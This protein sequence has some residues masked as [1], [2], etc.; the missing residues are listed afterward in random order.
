VFFL[1]KVNPTSKTFKTNN[2]SNIILQVSTPMATYQCNRCS[3]TFNQKIH[4]INHLKKINLCPPT[5]SDIL[6]NELLKE[7]LGDKY[8]SL[9]ESVSQTNMFTRLA[10][11]PCF[12]VASGPRELQKTDTYPVINN[13]GGI[14]I[15]ILPP[16][17]NDGETQVLSTTN[18]TNVGEAINSILGLIVNNKGIN[19]NVK[20]IK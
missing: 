6:P 11:G 7:V 15:F 4:L 2:I 20:N 16:L 5:S 18:Y 17:N 8:V 19:E 3:K 14:N 9:P 13:A 12:C 1:A 10:H